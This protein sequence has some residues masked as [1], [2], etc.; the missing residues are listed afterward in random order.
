MKKTGNKPQQKK[1]GKKP[2][3]KPDRKKRSN[4]WHPEKRERSNDT[5]PE[6]R[7]RSGDW[8]PSKEKHERSNDARPERRERSGDWRPSKEKRERSND[9]RPE[10]RERSGDWRSSKD[11]R[12]HTADR[13]EKRSERS[14]EGRF[15]RPMKRRRSGR[16]RPERPIKKF[17]PSVFMRR[18]EEKTATQAYVPQY[19]FADFA[20]DEQ[21]KKNIERKGYRTPTPIQDKVIPLLLEGKDVVATA[22]TGTGKTASFLIPLIHN[23]LTGK[24]SRVLIVAPTRELAHQ[25]QVELN[26]FKDRT[27]VYSTLCIGGANMNMQI[28]A[29]RRK[30]EF[31]V[32]T[33]GRLIDLEKSGYLDFT[34]FDTIVLDEV[35]TMM[36]MGFLNDIKYIIERLPQKR[37]SLFFSAT[38]PKELEQLM[39][40]FLHNPVSVSVKTRQS[41]ENVNQ[42]VVH[43]GDQNKVELLHEILIKPDVKKVIVFLRTKR[44]VDRL[45]MMLRERG[46]DVAVMHGDKTQAQRQKALAAFKKNR[47][48]ILLATDVV[49]RGIDID[50]V[51]HVI[52]Y[53]LPQTYEDYIHRIGRTGRADKIGHAITF[54]D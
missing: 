21:I 2:Y 26:T 33:P 45:A 30:P 17:D 1:Q 32:G 27:K 38:I 43:V 52:N 39:A 42:E 31:V 13:P 3:P 48:T 12:K 24:A 16:R 7:E 46:F 49:A 29:L 23:V 35:D 50:D 9:G 54:V 47:V 34:S 22:N 14:H 51:T 15:E 36:D 5:R 20:I 28:T 4:D 18:V 8:R 11:G 40:S 41:A 53:D 25:I 37:H 10:R 44:F 6:R 19:M